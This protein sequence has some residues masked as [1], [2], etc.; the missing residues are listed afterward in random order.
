MGI[1][2]LTS[3]PLTPERYEAN[4]AK[5]NPNQLSIPAAILGCKSV[6]QSVMLYVFLKGT[7]GSGWC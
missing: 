1:P 5:S 2:K 3:I 6:K 7:G 4:E